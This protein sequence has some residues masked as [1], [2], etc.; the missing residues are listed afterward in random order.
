LKQEGSPK[1]T[2]KNEWD[3]VFSTVYRKGELIK[4]PLKVG[5]GYSSL[6]FIGMKSK[7]VII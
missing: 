7:A 4:R 6:F 3:N 2:T 1:G 5:F